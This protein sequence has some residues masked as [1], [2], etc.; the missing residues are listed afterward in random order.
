MA[1]LLWLSVFQ[2]CLL[3][4]ILAYFLTWAARI[5]APRIGL[6]DRPD[7]KRKRH[8]KSTPLMGGMAI[9]LALLAVTGGFWLFGEESLHRGQQSDR[10]WLALL[11]SAGLTCLVGLWDDKFNM[12][13]RQKTFCQILACIPFVFWGPVVE[14]VSLMGFELHLG[15]GGVVFTFLWLFS[16]S[17]VVNL[18][19]G[20][21]G[22]AGT[23]GLIA[24]IALA[25]LS[26]IMGQYAVM[27]VS[28]VV[29]GS[30]VGFLM[31]NWPPA[32]IFMGDSGSLTVGFLV[33]AL[34]ILSSTKQAT[35]FTLIAPLVLISLP[36]FDTTMAILRRM[37]TGKGICAGDHAHIHHHLQER[38]LTRLQALLVLSAI[39]VAMAV[40]AVLSA[41]LQ[42]DAIGA[43]ACLSILA[44]LV[45]G[46][47]FGHYEAGLLLRR[48]PI[49]ESKAR[50][51][52][53]VRLHLIRSEDSLETR[54]ATSTG[55]DEQ[56]RRAA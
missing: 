22:L 18:A 17:T 54:V 10:T 5:V 25:V 24:T 53:S 23:I 13:A 47:V 38:G 41:R 45:A 27:L 2:A 37:L 40:A 12:Q 3:S 26:A 48:W 55:D 29:A 16:C 28:M 31:H 49:E 50:V 35:G 8:V 1:T 43:L 36:I 46:R 6:C 52:G 21:D 9:Y 39:C 32:K 34:S 20:M 15:A 30:L 44:A 33:G 42:S 14:S 56:Q 51:G 19:D 4:A 11:A 7:G